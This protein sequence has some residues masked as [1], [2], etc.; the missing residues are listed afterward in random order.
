MEQNEMNE[1]NPELLEAVDGGQTEDPNEGHWQFTAAHR[2]V[3][4]IARSHVW[5]RFKAGDTL[6]EVA[7]RFG[8]TPQEIQQMNP[9]T[10]D[11]DNLGMIYEG[12]TVVV[13]SV[14]SEWD[15]QNLEQINF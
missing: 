5:Y 13:K 8:M 4:F 3:P 12:D 9:E 2:G 6:G 1:L 15:W 10:I 11:E 7:A 14:P